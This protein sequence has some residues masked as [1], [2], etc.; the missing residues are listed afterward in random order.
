[1]GQNQ[2]MKLSSF[3]SIGFRRRA[4]TEINEDRLKT[5]LNVE[6]S[7]MK[8]SSLGLL[9]AKRS[10]TKAVVSLMFQ[11]K[12]KTS[13]LAKITSMMP[14]SFAVLKTWT[15]IT[16]GQWS[17]QMPVVKDQSHLMRCAQPA[18]M[19]PNRSTFLPAPFLNASIFCK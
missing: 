4:V 12:L 10:V 2:K 15:L 1:M 13:E 14:S 5:L 7:A 18:A 19:L 17:D 6:L 16:T 11:K 8:I 3:L 9:T